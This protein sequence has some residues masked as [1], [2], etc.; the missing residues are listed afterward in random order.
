LAVVE[1]EG[2]VKQRGLHTYQKVVSD[3]QF[4]PAEAIR[5]Y[6]LTLIFSDDMV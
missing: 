4:S 5:S 2:Q 3:C 1:A 6:A